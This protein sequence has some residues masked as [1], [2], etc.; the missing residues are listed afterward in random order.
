MD[1]HLTQDRPRP[2][3]LSDLYISFTLLAL[4][5]F[6]GVLAIVQHELVEKKRWMTREEFVEEWA[7]AQIMPGPNVVN[8]SLMIG[9]RYF[10]LPGALAA[11]AGML[12]LPL[13]LV[14]I[15]TFFYAQFAGHPGLAGALRG[16]GAV[17]AG[18]ITAAGLRLLSTL[19]THPLGLPV[20][21]AF[22]VACFAAI[23]LLRWPL[24]YVLP[25]L[26]ITAYFLTYRKIKP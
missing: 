26:G 2:Q 6:G 21:F 15:L 14:L 25:S 3:S 12:S 24:L 10:G 18:L 17:A 19:K 9:A 16:M 22:T 1:S 7:V 20:S 13:V 8:L 5:G 4:Q 23:A 11:L